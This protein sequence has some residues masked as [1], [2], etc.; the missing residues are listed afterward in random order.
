MDKNASE[1]CNCACKKN[2]TEKKNNKSQELQLS[3]IMQKYRNTKG[4]LIPVLHEAQAIFGCLPV[5]VQK[6]IAEGL[7]MPL[8]EIYGVATFYTQFCIEPKGIYSILVCMGTACFVKGAPEVLEKLKKILAIDIGQCTKD[9]R[10]SLDICRCIGAC[11]LAP[12]MTINGKVYGGLTPERLE[13]I[14]KTY[15]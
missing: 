6:Q 2:H 12:A 3:E 10:F 14:I 15:E 9:G 5:D 13:E 11:G 8:A 7:D 4:S 1:H